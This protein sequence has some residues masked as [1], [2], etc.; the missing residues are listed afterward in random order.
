MLNGLGSCHGG[1]MFA[2]ADSAFAFACNSHNEATVAAGCSIEFL[3]PVPPGAVLTAIAQERARVGRRG[4]Y[5]VTL[6]DGAGRV[7][8]LFCG[9][10]ARVAG[11]VI[12]RS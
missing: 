6:S 12:G 4:V 5:D 1:M 2:L 8:A 7:V 11:E 9:K 3:Q 10:S